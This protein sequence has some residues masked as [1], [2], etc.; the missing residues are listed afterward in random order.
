[1]SKERERDISVAEGIVRIET[2][3]ESLRDSNKS[4]LTNVRDSIKAE[5]GSL[6]SSVDKV[7]IGLIGIIA[8]DVG[9]KFIPHSPIDWIEGFDY[10][11]EFLSIF[12]WTFVSLRLLQLGRKDNH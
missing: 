8:A 4:E 1:M 6:K 12:T 5:I 10:L 3:L 7:M 11:T 2:K 9:T